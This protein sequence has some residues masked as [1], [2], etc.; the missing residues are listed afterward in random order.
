MPAV[1]NFQCVLV[2]GLVALFEVSREGL[3]GCIV[4]GRPYWPL[5]CVGAADSSWGGI[6]TDFVE[7]TPLALGS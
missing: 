6:F 5:V 1:W 2:E 3:V 7:A 4:W